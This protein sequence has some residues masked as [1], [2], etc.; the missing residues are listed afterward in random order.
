MPEIIVYG[1]VFVGNIVPYGTFEA[2]N[3]I[4]INNTLTVKQQ[5]FGR[6]N[7]CYIF[8]TSCE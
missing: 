1:S 4:G 5:Y 2:I 8:N 3:N 7:I 6:K